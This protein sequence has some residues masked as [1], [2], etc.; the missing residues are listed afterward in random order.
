ML[1]LGVQARNEMKCK[2]HRCCHV[3]TSHRRP[4]MMCTH[5]WEECTYT[6]RQLLKKMYAGLTVEAL[7]IAAE[8]SWFR[9]GPGSSFVPLIL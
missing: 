7:V 8:S 3:E 5:G 9:A 6:S 2:V 1:G 4:Q